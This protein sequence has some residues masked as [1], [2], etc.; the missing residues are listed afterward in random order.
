M[1]SRFSPK[2]GSASRPV[3]GRSR[4]PPRR[5]RSRGAKRSTTGASSARRRPCGS[6]RSPAEAVAGRLG[7]SGSSS[8]SGASSSS[9]NLDLHVGRPM[10]ATRERPEADSTRRS[11]WRRPKVSGE[12]QRAE[13]AR[14][15]PER[16]DDRLGEDLADRPRPA[17]SPSRPIARTGT[18]TTTHARRDSR[19]P[20][21]QPP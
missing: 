2:T 10:R 15:R 5:R 20:H 12:A 9:G 7:Q 6:R 13:R 11:T 21:A 17:H 19:Q 4:R 3:C 16:V 14:Q 8:S 18:M 1:S